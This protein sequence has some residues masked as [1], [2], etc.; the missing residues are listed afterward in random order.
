MS[1]MYKNY[2]YKAWPLS[3]RKYL[4]PFMLNISW[5]RWVSGL[6][7]S[8]EKSALWGRDSEKDV[9]CQEYSVSS[10]TM[11]FHLLQNSSLPAG[12]YIYI[13]ILEI[14]LLMPCLQ[15]SHYI[16][17]PGNNTIFLKRSRLSCTSQWLLSV[18]QSFGLTW[19]LL[20]VWQVKWNRHKN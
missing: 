17:E 18:I 16:L 5:E 15:I 11:G 20:L 13:Y 6:L 9:F 2:W 4:Q 19:I 1:D 12:W 8:V 3:L 7:I 10:L 14:F